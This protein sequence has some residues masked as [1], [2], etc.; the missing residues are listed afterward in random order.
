MTS[1]K[2]EEFS[3]RCGQTL[4]GFRSYRAHVP[5]CTSTN[6]SIIY[7]TSTVTA[8]PRHAV[9]NEDPSRPTNKENP[10]Q[11]M[12]KPFANLFDSMMDGFGSEIECNE[13]NECNNDS[14][15]TNVEDQPP[16]TPPFQGG[17]NGTEEWRDNIVNPSTVELP[18]V[19]QNEMFKAPQNFDDKFLYNQVLRDKN[20]MFR[21]NMADRMTAEEKSNLRLLRILK[22]NKLGLYDEVQ[23]WRRETAKDYGEHTATLKKPLSREKAIGNIMELY[24]YQHLKPHAV[25]LRLPNTGKRYK[26]VV[27]SFASMLLSLLT[28]PDAMQPNN[29]SFDPANPFQKPKVG[30]ESGVYSD[31]NTARV[32][33]DAHERYCSEPDQMLAE[34]TLFIDKTHLDGKGKHTVEP[35]MFTTGLFNQKFR[36]SEHAWRP[37][38]YLPNM[39]LLAPHASADA[40]QRD[41]HYCLRIILSELAAYQRIPR[42][43]FWTFAV[44]ETEIQCHLRI[45]V[46]C[47]IGDTD[48]HDRLCAQKTN[49]SG[50]AGAKESSPRLCRYCD[51]PFEFLGMPLEVPRLNMTQCGTIRKLRNDILNEAN[52]SKLSSLGYKPFHD[53]MVDIQ[54]SDPLTGLHGCTPAEVL[55]ALQL[56]IEERAIEACFGSKRIRKNRRNIKKRKRWDDEREGEEESDEEDVDEEDGES[57]DESEDETEDEAVEEGEDDQKD[58]DESDESEEEVE[59]SQEE[60]DLCDRIVMEAMD[61]KDTTRN[62]VFNSD[63]KERVDGLARKLHRFLR[64]QSEKRLPR[65]S[66]PRGITS[67]TKMQGNERSGVI[68]ILLLILIMDYWAAARAPATKKVFKSKEDGYLQEALGFERLA[69]IVKTLYLI[70]TFEAH[71]KATEVKRSGLHKIQPFIPWFLEQVFRVF[72]RKE[73]VGNN[74]I[75]NHLPMHYVGDVQRF[76]S[77]QNFNSGT[78]ESLHKSAIKEPGRRTNMSSET[79]EYLTGIRYVENITVLRGCRDL[80]RSAAQHRATAIEVGGPLIRVTK[81]KIFSRRLKKRSTNKIPVWDETYC[82]LAYIV[83]I[84]QDVI[85]P[86]LPAESSI[87]FYSVL[88]KDGDTYKANPC[89]GKRKISRQEWAYVDMGRDGIIP[90]QL[91]CLIEVLDKPASAINLHGSI[92][93]EPGKYCLVHTAHVPLA[94]EGVPP[95]HGPNQNEGTLAHIDQKLIHRVPKSS[96]SN[97]EWI[98]ADEENPPSV[99]F[100][101][102]KSIVGPCVAVPDI[103]S[104]NS[105]NEFFVLKSVDTWASLFEESAAEWARRSNQK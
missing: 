7:S 74:T 32:H 16:P 30:G 28:D 85:L 22:G 70:L 14:F 66:F 10:P 50:L 40:K 101:D 23:Q 78:G 60:S 55:H 37:L 18:L 97:G 80:R 105:A 92:I 100:V 82:S 93:D 12:P 57:E 43:I 79:T 83:S 102:A 11:T 17:D 54:F 5:H 94:D 103:L 24:G 73:G 42:G 67:L 99:I 29:L 25:T 58:K 69:N 1:P 65:T 13:N 19:I 104:A 47:V 98:F 87:Q 45:P 35:V 31:F 90:C 52:V 36:F 64:W 68:L 95:Y 77:A 46:N 6:T 53:G 71:M 56:G 49:R 61:E 51:V 38:G 15:P 9:A 3:C 81:H 91:L 48:G 59:L 8:A 4:Y 27:F 39:D 2:E 89:Y 62:N 75:K 20:V 26:L 76:G 34:I 86:N 41:Y 96:F 88:K 72:D 21:P 84:T 63:A 33:C 44:G